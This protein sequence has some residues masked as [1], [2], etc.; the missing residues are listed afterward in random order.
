MGFNDTSD[1]ILPINSDHVVA[2]G[3][4]RIKI[5]AN[6]TNEVL[7]EVLTDNTLYYNHIIYRPVSVDLNIKRLTI[8][9]AHNLVFTLLDAQDNIIDF[10]GHTIYI[11]LAFIKEDFINK[12]LRANI[13]DEFKN[14]L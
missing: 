3:I 10:N 7:F 14:N 13:I 2:L 8:K 12:A 5:K 9:N 1:K 4:S 6:F 11:Q